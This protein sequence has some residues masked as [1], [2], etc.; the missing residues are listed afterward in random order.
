MK[1]QAHI[2]I[3][4]PFPGPLIDFAQGASAGGPAMTKN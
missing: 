1:E 3:I 4:L 2:F